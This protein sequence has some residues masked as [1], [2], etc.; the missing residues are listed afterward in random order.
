MVGGEAYYH[1]KYCGLKLVSCPPLHL[2]RDHTGYEP[3]GL[4]QYPTTSNSLTSEES[5]VNLNV[6]LYAT[7]Q[8]PKQSECRPQ[9]V[10]LECS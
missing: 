3:T 2:N 6:P 8:K 1:T 7:V 4:Q 9:S 5:D 10:L